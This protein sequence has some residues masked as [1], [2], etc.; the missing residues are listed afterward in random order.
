MTASAGP[1][2]PRGGATAC[3]ARHVTP[4]TSRPGS[5]AASAAPPC[6]CAAHRVGPATRPVTVLAASAA[7][8]WRRR[9]RHPRRPGAAGAR[10]GERRL[11]SV[12]FVDLVASPPCPSGATR[13]RARAALAL[14]DTAGGWVERYGGVSENSSATLSWPSGHPDGPGGDAER[15]VRAALDRS[16]RRRPRS[17]VGADELAARAGVLTG[18]AAVTLGAG[19][20]DGRRLPGQHRGPHPGG[21]P[22]DVRS[23]MH[24]PGQQAALVYPTPGPPLSKAERAAVAPERWCGPRTAASAAGWR[25]RSPPGAVAAPVQVAFHATAES[26][27][28]V[29]AVEGVGVSAS[30]AGLSSRSTSTACW[31]VWWHR[32]LPAYGEA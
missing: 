31:S 2:R 14:L 24:S 7:R 3:G 29:V 27:G 16:S 28:P 8:P 10:G 17:E 11:V 9:R 5:S 4:G 25:R 6:C 26:A 18:G 19:A 22:R 12:L 21:A 13:G 30:P 20:R 15:A 23:A 1:T 32:P